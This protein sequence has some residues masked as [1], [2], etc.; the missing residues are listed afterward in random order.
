MS[1]PHSPIFVISSTI[2][3]YLNSQ[4]MCGKTIQCFSKPEILTCLILGNLNK[5]IISVFILKHRFHFIHPVQLW[6]GGKEGLEN[7]SRPHAA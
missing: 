6:L 3:S 5:Q 1:G 7:F 4:E 2:S